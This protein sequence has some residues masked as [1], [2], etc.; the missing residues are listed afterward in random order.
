M[1][2]VRTMADSDLEVGQSPSSQVGGVI[3]KF[4][5]DTFKEA[6]DTYGPENLAQ[7]LSI[8]AG[9]SVPS[10]LSFTLDSLRTGDA[11]IAPILDLFPVT[12]DMSLE[13]AYK[14]Y[15]GKVKISKM[16]Y[17]K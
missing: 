9:N 10:D 7:T 16:S 17:D 8:R 3:F 5:K 12:K 2:K 13:E 14:L 11:K 15:T 1:E 6:M 4:T